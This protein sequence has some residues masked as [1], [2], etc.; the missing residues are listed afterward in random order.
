MKSN[1]P[2]QLPVQSK[3]GFG[4]P[5]PAEAWRMFEHPDP[6]HDFGHA[7]IIEGSLCVSNGWLAIRADRFSAPFPPD[8][9]P[10]M[11]RRFTAIEFPQLGE[12]SAS[13]YKYR[14]LDDAVPQLFR[15]GVRAIWEK[16]M[17]RWHPRATPAVRVGGQGIVPMGLLQ[18]VSMLPAVEIATNALTGR[19]VPF[20]FK[21]GIGVL[22]N[23][24][25]EGPDAPAPYLCI[26]TP[27]LR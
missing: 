6:E 9:S 27:N 22:H 10:A 24:S 13:Y 18:A 17:L 23:W 19:P 3:R 26:F 5:V 1:D 7:A 16:G 11:A 4:F 21:G 14:A 12:N 25:K 20:R 8:A 2:S 15:H